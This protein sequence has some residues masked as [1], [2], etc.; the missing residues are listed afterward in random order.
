[1]NHIKNLET[2]LKSDVIV[3]VTENIKEIEQTINETKK[4]NE[5]KE[6]NAELEYMKQV[7]LYFN[8]VLL[9][10]E[11]NTI[12]EEQALDILEGLEDMRAENQ[13]V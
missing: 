7:Q 3:E 9:D 1:M 4:K 10:I 11:N 12:T 2:L 6:L 8:E 5:L 13:E